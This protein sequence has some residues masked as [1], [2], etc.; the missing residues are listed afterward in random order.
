M[1]EKKKLLSLEGKRD[2]AAGDFL[3]LVEQVGDDARAD[4]IRAAID[5]NL[6]VGQIQR[7]SS[8]RATAASMAWYGPTGIGHQ[9]TVI[10]I[11]GWNGEDSAG[12]TQVV[13]P[14]WVTQELLDA[15]YKLWQENFLI[16]S[17]T[18]DLEV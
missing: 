15:W 13:I 18:I 9:A 4:Q 14:G 3:A 5:R 12:I 2:L 17:A 10:E 8:G 16:P 11:T 1:S 7:L 6:T